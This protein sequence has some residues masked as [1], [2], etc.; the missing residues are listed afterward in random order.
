MEKGRTWGELEF[1]ARLLNF[2]KFYFSF[3]RFTR[4]S[5]GEF[6]AKEHK[7]ARLHDNAQFTL[8][9]PWLISYL[10]NQNLSVILPVITQTSLFF[11]AILVKGQS[12]PNRE[13]CIADDAS[14]D[15]EL[16]QFLKDIGHNQKI[17]IFREN[18]GHI[19]AA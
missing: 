7:L 9:G 14:D 3:K 12:Y 18:N 4:T 10:V 5:P 16:L 11:E 8:I 15:P 13:L 17:K 1:V 19:S 2:Y 6:K